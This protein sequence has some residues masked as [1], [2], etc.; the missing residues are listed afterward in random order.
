MLN[1]KIL[2][3]IQLPQLTKS[4]IDGLN[5]PLTIKEINL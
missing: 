4:E 1:E 3:R 2:K 5:T